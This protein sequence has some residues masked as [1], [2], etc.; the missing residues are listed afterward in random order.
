[1]APACF[2]CLEFSLLRS[3]GRHADGLLLA[4]RSAGAARH[5]RRRAGAGRGGDRQPAPLMQGTK[6]FACRLLSKH[7]KGTIHMASAF[8][9]FRGEDDIEAQV[10]HLA[11]EMSSLKKSLSRRGSDV[12][13]DARDTASDFYGELRDRFSDAL[14]MMRR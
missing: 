7:G 2:P 1:V 8:S 14:P 5:C 11:R 13:D 12:Y 4:R 10:A 6:R 9:R 3:A